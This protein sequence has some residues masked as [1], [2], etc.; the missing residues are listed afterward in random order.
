M[1]A[2]QEKFLN[3]LPGIIEL[4]QDPGTLT[5]IADNFANAEAVKTEIDALTFLRLASVTDLQVEDDF[6]DVLKVETDDNGIIYTSVNEVIKVTGNYY[7]VGNPDILSEMLG[8]YVVNGTGNQI[9][10]SK[11]GSKEMPSLIVRITSAL[12]GSKTKQVYVRDANFIGQIINGFLD[13]NRAGDLPNSPFE[14]E[15]NKGGD[16]FTYT[17]DLPA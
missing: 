4:V 1:S 5:V 10:G 8:K 7:E 15:G 2:T 11:I 16:T 14:F 17:D 6:S 3:K 13:V 12:P 9:V